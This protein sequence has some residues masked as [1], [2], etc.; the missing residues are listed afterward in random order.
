MEILCMTLSYGFHNVL[1]YYKK[2]CGFSAE[3][4]VDLFQNLY[5]LGL[6]FYHEP[7]FIAYIISFLTHSKWSATTK[8]QDLPASMVQESDLLVL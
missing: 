8:P 5:E 6:W 1:K 7:Y 3:D 2:S 4:K